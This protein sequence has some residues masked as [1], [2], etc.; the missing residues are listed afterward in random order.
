MLR[1]WKVW[2]GFAASAIAI[3]L[4]FRNVRF[5]DLG[6]ALAGARLGRLLPAAL[7]LAA[8]FGARAWR[9]DLLMGSPSFATTF[10]AMNIGYLLNIVLPLRLGEVGRAV[11]IAARTPI[12]VAR[13]FS[14]VV[15]ERLL[16]LGGVVA[17]FGLVA[18]VVPVPP[19][20]ASAA[21]GAGAFA[22]L[23]LAATGLMLWQSARA[24][25]LLGALLQRV[26]RHPEPWLQRFRD[27]CGGFRAVGSARRVLLVLALT[28]VIWAT[29]IAFSAL[30][31]GAFLAPRIDQASLVVVTANLGGALPSAPGG[32]GIVQGFATSALVLPFGVR[33]D[34][35]LAYVLVW[36]LGQQLVLL[37]LG[38]WGLG[39][40]GMSFAQV[41]AGALQAPAAAADAGARPLP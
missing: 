36:S 17:L 10:H 33:E 40:I 34:L 35:A 7:F 12:P 22:L 21:A 2:L 8:S 29:A 19:A 9:W 24:E 16:D 13:A 39:R 41:R 23:V 1:N 30:L 6:T 38:L 14:S 31:L 20:F 4:T 27:L 5:A 28:V 18:A 26:T 11:V 32:L 37:L 3:Y 15:V 25:L